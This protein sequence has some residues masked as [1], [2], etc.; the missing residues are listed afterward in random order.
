MA[1]LVFLGAVFIGSYVQS[2]AGFAIG[3]IVMAAGGA[4]G[5]ISLPALT[6]AV[7]II[8]FINIVVALKGHLPSV[9]RQ[10]FGWLVA[11]Q[12]PAVGL[13]VWLITVL[14]RDAQWVLQML[15]G[16]FITLG[17]LSMM[18]RPVP[19]SRL[20]PR[21]ACFTAGVSG[22]LIGGMFSAS[23]PIIG[24]FTYRQPLGLAAIRATMLAFFALATCTRTMIVGFQGG[25]TTEVL[26]LSF[27]ALPFVV[28]GAWLG[29]TMPPPITETVMKRSVFCLLF[30]MGV[31]I[32]YNAL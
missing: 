3:M 28:S 26:W 10:L 24:W 31:Y 12:I 4:S 32:V 5:S 1:W 18:V 2:V 7:S 8:S 29:R 9:N 22:G 25:L 20:S 11:G 30:L 21:W 6:A 16:I 14:D 23:G 17:S 19:L 27:I 15:L 13:G